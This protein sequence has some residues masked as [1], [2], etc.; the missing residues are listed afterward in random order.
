MKKSMS[1]ILVLSMLWGSLPII[2][3]PP[4]D[5]SYE[6]QR[7]Y[8]EELLGESVDNEVVASF[9]TKLFLEEEGGETV[10]A[11]SEEYFGDKLR[12][13]V[14]ESLSSLIDHPDETVELDE[15]YT[16]IN[17]DEAYT[18]RPTVIGG[19]IGVGLTTGLLKIG[20]FAV[21]SPF[22]AGAI[23]VAGILFAAGGFGMSAQGANSDFTDK[24]SFDDINELIPLHD[25]GEKSVEVHYRSH[26]LVSQARYRE[27]V[28]RLIF[29]YTLVEDTLWETDYKIQ[30]CTHGSG[31]V[32]GEGS[33]TI[34]ERDMLRAFYQKFL[35]T[36]GNL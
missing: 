33:F 11:L 6:K 15:D 25:R 7:E 28:C 2:A 1:I 29:D 27:G 4:L 31:G 23:V 26:F 16:Y 9:L 22:G 36:E 8:F 21:F 3:Q 34:D 35:E 32:I 20:G 30:E 13:A 17:F 14:N 5:F 19:L 18:N 10:R 12:T 24:A